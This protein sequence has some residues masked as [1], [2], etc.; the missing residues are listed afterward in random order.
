MPVNNKSVYVKACYLVAICI[1]EIDPKKILELFVIIRHIP[2]QKKLRSIYI[3]AGKV[4]GH[5]H[6]SSGVPDL[7][8]FESDARGVG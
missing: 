4:S 8:G 6:I 7:V 2:V 3:K 5:V 1:D